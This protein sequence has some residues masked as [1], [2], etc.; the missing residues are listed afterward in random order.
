MPVRDAGSAG[1]FESWMER[2]HLVALDFDPSVMG[3]VSAPIDRAGA[4]PPRGRTVGTAE[5]VGKANKV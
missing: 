5:F 3:I 4:G 1:R 2:D